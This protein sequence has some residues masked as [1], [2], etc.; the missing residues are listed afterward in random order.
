MLI[1]SIPYDISAVTMTVIVQVVVLAWRQVSKERK[2]RFG[3]GE[4]IMKASAKVTIARWFKCSTILIESATQYHH[5][6]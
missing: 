2:K 6:L 5:L 3:K 1:Y 4:N